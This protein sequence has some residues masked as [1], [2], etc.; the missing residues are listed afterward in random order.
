M[1]FVIR[2]PRDVG[3]SFYFHIKNRTGHRELDR[4]GI[5]GADRSLELY[6]FVIAE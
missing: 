4:K 1:L 6:D 3:V 5:T 2:D